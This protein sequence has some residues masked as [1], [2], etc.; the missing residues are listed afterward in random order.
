VL[1]GVPNHVRGPGHHSIV[2]GPDGKDWVVYHA[3]N[4]GL[5]VRQM[6]IDPLHWTGEGP[7]VT[8]SWRPQPVPRVKR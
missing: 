7:R 3:W 8:P 5:T 2:T 1:H 6:C 4:E